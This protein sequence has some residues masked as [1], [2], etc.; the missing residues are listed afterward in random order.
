[1]YT[2]RGRPATRPHAHARE[3]ERTE[4]MVAADLRR[5]LSSGARLPP[6]EAH[7]ER[8]GPDFLTLLS[9]AV[10]SQETQLCPQ[11]WQ[12]C[13]R[14][15][16]RWARSNRDP[17]GP[18]PTSALG[19]AHCASGSAPQGRRVER[20]WPR[21]RGP[22]ERAHGHQLS[23]FRACPSRS[24]CDSGPHATTHSDYFREWQQLAQLTL[25]PHASS[26]QIPRTAS[27]CWC[28]ARGRGLGRSG[29]PHLHTA[30]RGLS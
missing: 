29:H 3:R 8:T 17:R 4:I 14:A 15:K 27:P 16:R 23:S 5:Q 6:W 13:G 30:P 24:A 2:V 25:V 11:A 10:S 19:K 22:L 21:A 1:M 20:S 26:A 7:Q 12:R 18:V 9:S 28:P